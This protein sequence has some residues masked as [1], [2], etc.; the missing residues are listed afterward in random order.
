MIKRIVVVLVLLV[1]FTVNAQSQKKLP[2]E[3]WKKAEIL[4]F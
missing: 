4:H 1:A 3:S 2:K